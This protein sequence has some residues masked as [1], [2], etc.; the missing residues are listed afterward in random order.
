MRYVFM[1]TDITVCVLMRFRPS[2]VVR[3]A[4]H[5]LTKFHRI[6]PHP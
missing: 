4:I 2:L 1:V 6:F 3:A 5:Y